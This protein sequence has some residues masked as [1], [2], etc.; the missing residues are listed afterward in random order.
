MT[1]SVSARHLSLVVAVSLREPGFFVYLSGRDWC[2]T[3]GCP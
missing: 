1:I 3:W 2:R